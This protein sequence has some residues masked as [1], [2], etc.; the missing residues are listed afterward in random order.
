MN[1]G[2]KSALVVGQG[3]REEIDQKQKQIEYKQVSHKDD[4]VGELSD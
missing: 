3:R 2:V 4:Y 1:E